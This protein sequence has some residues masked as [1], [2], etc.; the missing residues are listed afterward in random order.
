MKPLTYF[1]TQTLAPALI[2]FYPLFMI[3]WRQDTVS[4]LPRVSLV[5]PFGQRQL[6]CE[7]PTATVTV[8]GI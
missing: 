2:C 6:E 8:T 3:R 1:Y 4:P 7:L 5:M